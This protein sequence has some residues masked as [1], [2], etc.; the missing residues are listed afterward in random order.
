MTDNIYHFIQRHLFY[1][2]LMSA[3]FLSCL[4]SASRHFSESSHQA[5]QEALQRLAKRQ[6][7]RQYSAN[8]NQNK[9][10]AL[11]HNAL[12]KHD[13]QYNN[14]NAPT[15][16]VQASHAVGIG[17]NLGASQ[18]MNNLQSRGHHAR[19]RTWDGQTNK[20][21]SSTNLLGNNEGH[22]KRTSSQE[23]IN[24]PSNVVSNTDPPKQGHWVKASSQ[25]SLSSSNSNV[26][27][28]VDSS[29]DT[30]LYQT[31]AVQGSSQFQQALQQ[32]QQH[33][34]GTVSNGRNVAAQQLQRLQEQKQISFDMTQQSKAKHQEKVIKT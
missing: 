25:S 22:L 6:A 7:A 23:Q 9:N 30:Y 1:H 34:R 19:G 21:R 27:K 32:Q 24:K 17:S 31:A 5:I 2:N 28:P 13:Q 8:S 29:H 3:C 18:S 10:N 4:L 26:V 12:E 15:G 16:P 14:N 11:T 20:S 33:G